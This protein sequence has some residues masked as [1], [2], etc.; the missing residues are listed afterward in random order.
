LNDSLAD[1][2][3]VEPLSQLAEELLK[4]RR[5]E[6]EGQL[7]GL[8]SR[9][10]ERVERTSR[11]KSDLTRTQLPP[12]F[13]KEHLVVPC[14]AADLLPGGL[15]SIT[16]EPCLPVIAPVTTTVSPNSL[17]QL[18]GSIGTFGEFA[19]PQLEEA[20]RTGKMPM[21]ALPVL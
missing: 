19:I 20:S 12:L 21:F 14:E 7:S 1:V 11:E 9:I 18:I 16:I 3:G 4:S 2:A 13:L 5:V 17:K 6:G 15:V 8:A 10:S